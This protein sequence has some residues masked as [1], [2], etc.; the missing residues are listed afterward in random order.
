MGVPATLGVSASGRSPYWPEEDRQANG[1]IQGTLAAVRAS[2]PFAFMGPMNLWL[3]AAFTTSLTTTNGSLS[4]DVGAA[5]ALAAGTSISST[6]LPKGTTMSTIGGGGGVTTTLVLPIYTYWAK[7]KTGIA[8]I[9]DLESTQWLL[10]AAVS[11]R[12]I[13]AGTTVLSIDTPAVLPTTFQPNGVKGTVTISNA[14]TDS[15]NENIKS[16]FEFAID[17]AAIVAG[18]DSA[19]VFTGAAILWHATVQLER[20]FD[21]GA[22]WLPCNIGGSGALAQWIGDG[23]TTGQPVSLSFGEP[24]RQILYRLNA[25]AYTGIT[26]TSLNYRISETGQAATTLAVPTIS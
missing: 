21:G 8:K 17:A 5:G 9:T 18:T 13:P 24:E 7:S 11:G 16:P 12:G 25:L 19:A 26:T 14:I 3:W 23:S 10:G 4:A 2:K 15:P 1:V 20:C 22:T 6:L